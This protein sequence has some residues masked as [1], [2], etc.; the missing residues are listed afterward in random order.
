MQV[1]V[2]PKQFFETH[3]VIVSNCISS[4]YTIF[5]HCLIF[6]SC[7]DVQMVQALLKVL[8]YFHLES[9]RKYREVKPVKLCLNSSKKMSTEEGA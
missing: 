8:H 9:R 4:M 5:I 7:I 6:S 1:N 2:E 3:Y